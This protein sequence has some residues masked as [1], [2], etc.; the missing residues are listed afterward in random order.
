VMISL[1]ML[2]LNMLMLLMLMINISRSFIRMESK[3]IVWLLKYSVQ[4]IPLLL[5]K[6]MT[7]T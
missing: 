7:L 6:L 5:T 2:I 4:L 1:R 3:V